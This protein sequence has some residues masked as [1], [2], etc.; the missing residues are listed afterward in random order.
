MALRRN[1]FSAFPPRCLDEPAVKRCTEVACC[2]LESA[3]G[4]PV[5]ML[6]ELQILSLDIAATSLFSYMLTPRATSSTC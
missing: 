4:T 5:D 2:R 6:H 1:A 3:R